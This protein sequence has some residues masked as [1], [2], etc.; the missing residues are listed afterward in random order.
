MS[1]TVLAIRLS[2]VVMAGGMALWAFLVTLNNVTDFQSNFVFVQHVLSMDTVFPET[3]LKWRAIT[4]PTIQAVAFWVIIA[5]E[6][7]TSLAVLAAAWCM[8]TKLWAS[9]AEFQKAKAVTAIGIVLGFG[10]WFIGFI[11]IAGEWFVM[12][13]SS[14]WNA[15]DDSFYFVITILAIGIYVFLDNDGNP[16]RSG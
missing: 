10:L 8:A 13:Q 12:W 16:D 3:T 6:A 1:F 15:Q 14:T 2:K 9:K 7:L 11:A 5:V 4:D